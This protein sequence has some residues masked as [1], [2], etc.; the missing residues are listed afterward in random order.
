MQS[1]TEES[2]AN[3]PQNES[4]PAI[5]FALELPDQDGNILQSYPPEV[6]D[7]LRTLIVRLGISHPFPGPASFDLGIERRRRYLPG[8]CA[9]NHPG[10]RQ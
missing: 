4:I 6:V 10:P 7:S 8:G 1:I 2:E 3:H 5:N 9:G